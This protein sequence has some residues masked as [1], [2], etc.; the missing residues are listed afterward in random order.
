MGDMSND[1]DDAAVHGIPHPLGEEG[2]K[3]ELK[4][5]GTKGSELDD[6]EEEEA[7]FEEEELVDE[8]EEEGEEE[9]SDYAEEADNDEEEALIAEESEEFDSEDDIPL[10]ALKT[11]KAKTPTPK[12]KKKT[13][14]KKKTPKKKTPRKKKETPTK[15]KLKRSESNVSTKSTGGAT[16]SIVTASSELYSKCDKGRLV[17]SL[18]CRWWYAVEWPNRSAILDKPPK[19]YDAL[20]G[21]PGVYICTRGDDVG[22]IQDLRDRGSCP[23]FCNF[24]KKSS[25]ELIQLLSQAI[26]K[27]KQM[28]IQNEGTNTQTQKDLNELMKWTNTLNPD[29][30]DKDA[31]KVFRAFAKASPKMEY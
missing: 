28:L 23:S 20:D 9:E 26:S 14:K 31:D 22:K 17:Q 27:Q 11:K 16:S 30:L 3:V 15:K 13:S 1:D 2:G 10:S 21:F 7:E 19:N 4:A 24:S 6:E 25:R 29:K 5:A 12:T 8:D 18:L